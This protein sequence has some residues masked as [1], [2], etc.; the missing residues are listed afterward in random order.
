MPS[1]TLTMSNSRQTTAVPATRSARVV[2]PSCFPARG[3]G[4]PT[5][6]RVLARHP[7]TDRDAAR[8]GACEA[9]LRPLRSGRSPLGA[10][11]RRFWAGGRASARGIVLRGSFSELL[12]AGSWCPAGGVR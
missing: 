6:A 5:G 4:A 9:P 12:A 11:L 8:R 7:Q 1:A 3:S 2:R 10:P